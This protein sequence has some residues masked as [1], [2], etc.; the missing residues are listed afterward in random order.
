M[1]DPPILG[2]STRIN[3]KVPSTVGF[4]SQLAGSFT[5]NNQKC[6]ITLSATINTVLTAVIEEHN[7]KSK[8]HLD[9]KSFIPETILSAH[10]DQVDAIFQYPFL[11]MTLRPPSPRAPTPNPD[12]TETKQHSTSTVK[13]LHPEPHATNLTDKE[14]QNLRFVRELLRSML[15]HETAVTGDIIAATAIAYVIGHIK[16]P[17]QEV[18]ADAILNN[19]DVD[20][21]IHYTHGFEEKTTM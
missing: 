5:H 16:K 20:A 4:S 13:Q 7:R 21:I 10:P 3:S 1:Y 2:H 12:A 17:R 11:P 19:G 6:R 15:A 18:I 8:V 9:N 14:Y